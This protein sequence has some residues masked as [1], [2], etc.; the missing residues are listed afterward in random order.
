[1]INLCVTFSSLLRDIT[2]MKPT[3]RNVIGLSAR[4]YDPLGLLSPVTVQ[5]KMLFQDVCAARLNWDEMLSGVLLTK[6]N[7]LLSGLEQSQTL[8]IP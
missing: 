5:F 7:C 4:F 8:C 3:M 2:A 1:M 6:W